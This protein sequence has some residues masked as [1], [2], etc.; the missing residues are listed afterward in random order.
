MA[1][2]GARNCRFAFWEATHQSL[3]VKLHTET[4]IALLTP[5]DHCLLLV[6]LVPQEV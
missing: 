1:P 5:P 4:A 3:V 2:T 6:H